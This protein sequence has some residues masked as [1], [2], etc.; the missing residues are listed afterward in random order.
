MAKVCDAAATFV[1]H[2]VHDHKHRYRARSCTYQVNRLETL[3]SAL[4]VR[5]EDARSHFGGQLQTRRQERSVLDNEDV[6]QT[7]LP[8]SGST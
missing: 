8:T 1:T 5:L 6:D 4:I 7:A 3:V 2:T